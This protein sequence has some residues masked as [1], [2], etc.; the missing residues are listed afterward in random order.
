MCAMARLG[1]CL[2]VMDM[3]WNWMVAVVT[4]PYECTK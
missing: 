2:G 1:F 4:H 3:F